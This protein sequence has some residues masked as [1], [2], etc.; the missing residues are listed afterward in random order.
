MS[1]DRRQRQFYLRAEFA[2]AHYLAKEKALEE[3]LRRER[4]R[5]T[6]DLA[7][8]ARQE[9]VAA[10]SEA[11]ALQT[12]QFLSDRHN[13][14]QLQREVEE[15]EAEA[16]R[17]KQLERDLLRTIESEKHWLRTLESG[18]GVRTFRTLKE[19]RQEDE[20]RRR[21]NDHA[22]HRLLPAPVCAADQPEQQQPSN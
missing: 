8:E 1:E 13:P 17:L 16:K 11:I 15:R 3:R 21:A 5:L 14:K 12:E 19:K 4:L 18:N 22:E 20:Y 10:A 6:N 9:K 2:H 7:K